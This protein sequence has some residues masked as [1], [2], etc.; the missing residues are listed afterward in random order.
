VIAG[1]SFLG[2]A[3]GVAT[4]II[5]TSVMNGFRHEFISHVIGFNGHISL[6]AEDGVGNYDAI[7][8]ELKGEHVS[9]V[10]PLIERQAM[11]VTKTQVIGGIVRGLAQDNL[12]RVVSDKIFTGELCSGENIMLGRRLA[13]RLGVWVGGEVKVI[14]PELSEGGF[15]YIPRAKT[16]KV[17]GIFSA[18]MYEYDSSVGFIS[19]DYAQRLFNLPNV[20]TQFEVTARNPELSGQ[21]KAQIRKIADRYGLIA[22]DWQERNSAFMNAVAVERNVMFLILTL[23][24]M[25]ASFSII[26]CM[27]MLVREKSRAIA[28]LRTIGMQKSAIMRVF[29]MIGFLI[30][31][32]GTCIGVVVGLLF[33]CNIEHIRRFMESLLS[34]NLFSEE[35]YY[36]SKLPAEVNADEVLLTT[37]I[38]LLLSFLSTI[39]PAWRASK[40]DPA[41]ALRYE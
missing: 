1:F 34:A 29:M 30:G 32:I 11:F 31:G 41:E 17:N 37:A 6:Y 19:L 20:V 15:G 26:S 28:V 21:I 27:V 25:V 36:L 24:I 7:A 12:Q 35:I 13:E 16:F 38:A 8:Q 23:I 40:I 4:L 2:I 18:G 22:L 9:N 39:Y 33:S 5:V 3:L 10:T 14:T